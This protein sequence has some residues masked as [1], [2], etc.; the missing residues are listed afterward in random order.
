MKTPPSS[1]KSKLR[2]L[3]ALLRNHDGSLTQE[4]VL[5]PGDFGLGKVPA[6]L[7]PDA[8]TTDRKSV[9]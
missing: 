7:K 3:P 9:V 4:L 5:R 1:I 2:S 6:R 8:T